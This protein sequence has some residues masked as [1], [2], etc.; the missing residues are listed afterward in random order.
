MALCVTFGMLHKIVP[1]ILNIYM[2]NN[3]P[4]TTTN[5]PNA[6]MLSAVECEKAFQGRH[7]GSTCE[8]I[9]IYEAF[10]AAVFLRT[11]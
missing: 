7:P 2:L 9:V 6:P 5:L 3:V 10:A 1:T 8:Q 11:G 4:K